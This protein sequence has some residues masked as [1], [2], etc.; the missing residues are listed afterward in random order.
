[1]T[2]PLSHDVLAMPQQRFSEHIIMQKEADDRRGADGRIGH[3][4]FLGLLPFEGVVTTNPVGIEIVMQ[5]KE[6][7]E[8]AGY[9]VT[10]AEM[11]YSDPFPANILKIQIKEFD[12][13]NFDLLFRTWGNIR[14]TLTLANHEGKVLFTTTVQEYGQST[15]WHYTEGYAEAVKRSFTGVLNQIVTAASTEEFRQALKR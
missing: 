8:S 9:H 3:Q 12:F 1:M 7:L 4:F 10:L 5:V 15:H 13:K 11:P 14:L 6:A 2:I